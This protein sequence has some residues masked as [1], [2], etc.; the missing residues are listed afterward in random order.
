MYYT[1]NSL[2][3]LLLAI[4]EVK[5]GNRVLLGLLGVE[6]FDQIFGLNAWFIGERARLTALLSLVISMSSFAELKGTGFT[7]Q[8]LCLKCL[9]APTVHF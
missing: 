2:L 9:N 6:S 4:S 7:K 1:L 5:V 8:S 3:L